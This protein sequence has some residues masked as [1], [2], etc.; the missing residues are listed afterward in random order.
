MYKYFILF[1]IQLH[2]SV[3]IFS[4]Y[5]TSIIVTNTRI[6]IVYPVDNYKGT[7]LVL[8]GWNFP[9]DDICNK[10]NF[11]VLAKNKGYT[12]ILP[13]MQKSVYASQLYPET[14]HDWRK[15][16][17]LQWVLDTLIPYLQKNYNLLLPHQKNYLF[18]ISTGGRG[19]ALIACYYKNRIFKAGAALSGDF[20][21]TLMKNDNLMKGYYGSYEQFPFRWKGKDN[22]NRNSKLIHI[23]LYLAHGENDPVVPFTQSKIFFETLKKTS[24]LPHQLN[25]IPSAKHDYTFWSSQ[26]ENI[27]LFFEKFK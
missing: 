25:I 22:P 7:I 26:Y 14:R 1:I 15:Y 17:T 9:C 8:P 2:F 6:D 19:V 3:F 23:P 11:C 21:Q 20:D 5:D 4:Q 13:D 24:H 12:L 10:S 16:H 27:F 18:G